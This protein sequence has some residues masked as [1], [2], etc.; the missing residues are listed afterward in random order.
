M[1]R[2]HYPSLHLSEMNGR[3]VIRGRFP[4][5]VDGTVIDNYLIEATILKDYPDS[6]PPFREIGG[7][8]PREADWHV[9]QNGN[10]C[11]FVPDERWKHWPRGADML[12]FL[13]GPVNDYF[14]SQTYR[15]LKGSYPFGERSHGVLGKWEYYTEEL[16]TIDFLVISKCLTYLSAD[17]INN[18][19]P[20]YCRSGK[21]LRDCHIKKVKDLRRKIEPQIAKIS[22]QDFRGLYRRL[23]GTWPPKP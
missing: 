3:W 14:C 7:R 23:V 21:L 4:V 1:L 17:S 19:W 12:D 6:V 8:I 11:P 16:E 5:T 18:G 9:Y 2:R 15:Q 13:K 22:L 10:C 20:C